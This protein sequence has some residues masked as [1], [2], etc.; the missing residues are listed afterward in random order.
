VS[1]LKVAAVGQL[2]PEKIERALNTILVPNM[3][4]SHFYLLRTSN[5]EYLSL[6]LNLQR[7]MGRKKFYNPLAAGIPFSAK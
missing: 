3:S 6:R 1:A 5:D 2:Q 7:A 4:M